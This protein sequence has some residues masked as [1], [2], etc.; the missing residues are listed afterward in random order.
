MEDL[1]IAGGTFQAT[2]NPRPARQPVGMFPADPKEASLVFLEARAISNPA[3]HPD[4][5]PPLSP[6]GERVK[7][8]IQGLG[9]GDAERHARKVLGALL[10][11]NLGAPSDILQTAP[12]QVVAM[13]REHGDIQAPKLDVGTEEGFRLL[14]LGAWYGTS[15][16]RYAYDS[17]GRAWSRLRVGTGYVRPATLAEIQAFFKA[18]GSCETNQAREALGSVTSQ[19]IQGTE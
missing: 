10:N 4:A 5:I 1:S 11:E 8:A 2:P 7:D 3:L 9:C 18:L 17:T 12:G 19:V 15:E 14:L 16:S 6:T 13:L